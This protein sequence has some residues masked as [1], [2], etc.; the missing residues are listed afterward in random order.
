MVAVMTGWV[1]VRD[2]SVFSMELIRIVV[3]QEL[4]SLNHRLT[5]QSQIMVVVV[6]VVEGMIDMI[7]RVIVI[8]LDHR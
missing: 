8:I 4:G 3:Y 7:V 1:V 2:I 6:V 5:S